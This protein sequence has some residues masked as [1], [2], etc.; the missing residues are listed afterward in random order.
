MVSTSQTVLPWLDRS[1]TAASPA[2]AVKSTETEGAGFHPF[3]K[4]GFSFLDL[5]DV[6]NPLHHIPMVGPLYRDI[7]G[8][9][10]DL[11]PRI[12]GSTLF[13]GPIGAGWPIRVF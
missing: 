4:D 1:V 8:D 3:G 5:I 11:L 7:T 10:I 2:Q 6:V 13:F 9:V 12:T